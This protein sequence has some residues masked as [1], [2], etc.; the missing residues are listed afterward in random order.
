MI[1]PL[2]TLKADIPLPTH[3]QK[4]VVIPDEFYIEVFENNLKQK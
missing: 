2:C 1:I 3:K 4:K